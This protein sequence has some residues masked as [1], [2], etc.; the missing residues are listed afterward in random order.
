MDISKHQI[1]KKCHELGLAIES[2]DASEELTMVASRAGHLTTDVEKLVDSEQGMKGHLEAMRESL[3][4]PQ[5]KYENDTQYH[6]IVDVIEHLLHDAQFSPS[7]VREAAVLACIHFEM[8]TVHR[9]QSINY[10][11]KDA[12]KVL[13][14]FRKEKTSL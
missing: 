10:K 8:R 14:D 12:L 7:E 9:F 3:K 2:C 1:L 5:G 13:S 4:T 11:V 6:Q